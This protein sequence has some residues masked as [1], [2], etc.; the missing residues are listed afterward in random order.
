MWRDSCSLSLSRVSPHCRPSAMVS[1]T[2]IRSS[3]SCACACAFCASCFYGAAAHAD[4][5]HV[6]AC[7]SAHLCVGTN[8]LGLH[9]RAPGD[10]CTPPGSS[11]PQLVLPW[12]E[13][14]L[15]LCRRLPAPAARLLWGL[16][17]PSRS[18]KA[19]LLQC[20]GMPRAHP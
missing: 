12:L 2:S 8:G 15:T 18:F 3:A 14:G 7:C 1:P 10:G 4:G 16:R 19:E 13:T 5:A 20:L 17:Q 6:A 9:V 11:Q